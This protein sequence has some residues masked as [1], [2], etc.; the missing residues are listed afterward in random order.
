MALKVSCERLGG[1]VG[2]NL[3]IELELLESSVLPL[4]YLLYPRVSETS[5]PLY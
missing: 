3:R 5:M 1:T 2:R 4:L